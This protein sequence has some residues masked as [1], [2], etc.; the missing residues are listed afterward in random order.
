[1]W[2]VPTWPEYDKRWF[3][4]ACE[5]PGIITTEELY[6]KNI[7]VLEKIECRILL[8][9]KLCEFSNDERWYPDLPPG[10]GVTANLEI[11]TYHSFSQKTFALNLVFPSGRSVESGPSFI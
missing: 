10:W 5:L 1:M 7:C 3:G 8:V 2:T 4:L 11:D 9:E 6:N